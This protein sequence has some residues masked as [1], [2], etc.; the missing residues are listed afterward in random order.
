MDYKQK[1]LEIGVRAKEAAAALISLNTDTKNKALTATADILIKEKDSII[2]ANAIDLK[3]GREKNLS[4]AMLDRLELNEKRIKSMADALKQITILEDPVGEIFDVKMRPNGL[5]IGRMR[6][7]IGVIGIIYEARPNVTTDAASLC[8]KSGNAVILRGGSESINSNIKLGEIFKKG[9]EEAGIHPYAVQLIPIPD[10]EMVGEMLRMNQYIDLIIPRGGKG[11]IE[12]VVAESTIPVIKHYDGNCFVYVDEDADIEMAMQIVVNAKTQRPGVCNAMETLLVHKAIA[13]KF[14]PKCCEELK[15]KGVEI[16][17]CL[18]TCGI[19]PYA[20][21]AIEKDYYE[22]FLDLI[23]AVKVIDSFEDA[24]KFINKYSSHHTDAIVTKD[25]A[26]ANKFVKEVDSACVFVNCS[27]RF[28]DGGEFGM[29]AEI[30]ISTD[31]LHARGP[32]ALKE[33]TSAKFIAF[34]NGQIRV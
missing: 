32:M 13:D 8:L 1:M 12:R 28:S 24:V 34:G 27:T 14:L 10:R 30:G 20:K 21:S 3:A 26:K 9:C 4:K 19:I 5:M 23:I 22:E 25:Y 15:K 16:R 33:I 7:P 18:K 29:G 17:G 6:V 11:L 31:K 2:E